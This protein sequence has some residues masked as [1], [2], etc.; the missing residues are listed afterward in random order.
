M[1]LYMLH[2]MKDIRAYTGLY[3]DDGLMAVRSNPKEI[4]KISQEVQKIYKGEGLRITID[5]NKK[6]VPFLDLKLDISNRTYEPYLK[7]GNI[8]MYVNTN[9][10]HPP[11]V[12]KAIPIGINHRLAQLSIDKEAFDRNKEPYQ[13]ALKESGY[14]HNLEFYK[15]PLEKRV[16]KYNLFYSAI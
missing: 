7:E 4:E 13:R 2:R 9:S 14:S 3:R 6:K 16:K 10:N 8:P 15:V 5:A 1:G 11:A 12:I